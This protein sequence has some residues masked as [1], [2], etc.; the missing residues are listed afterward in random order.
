[1]FFQ[2]PTI[3]DPR[4]YSAHDHAIFGGDPEPEWLRRAA[5]HERVLAEIRREQHVLERTGRA[6][7][8][9]NIVRRLFTTHHP[10]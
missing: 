9:P 7:R 4:Y 3:A 8:R 10:A 1:M 6:Q 2:G 5:E